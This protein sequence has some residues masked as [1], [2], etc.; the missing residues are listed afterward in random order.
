M[1]F[2]GLDCHCGSLPE[3]ERMIKSGFLV[4]ISL[5]ILSCGIPGPF[6]ITPSQYLI[7]RGDTLFAIA[8]RYDL[9]MKT[10]ASWNGIHPPF[11]IHPGQRLNLRPPP[12]YNKSATQKPTSAPQQTAERP[13]ILESKP[14]KLPP[15]TKPSAK[16][17]ASAPEKLPPTTKPPGKAP[18][19]AEKYPSNKEVTWGWPT[20][21]KVVAEFSANGVGKTGINIQ[22]KTGQSVVAAASGKVVYSGNGL[23]GYGELIIIKHSDE[24]LSAYAYNRKRLVKEGSWA[25]KGQRIAELGGAGKDLS[26]LHFEIRKKGKP[27]N[28][29]KYLPPH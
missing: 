7:R 2:R 21:G 15:T 18:A 3:F 10:L 29:L 16:V 26:V 23:K 11:V 20:V 27:V 9:E 6:N 1:E 14:E 17:S 4:L 5:A 28:P 19:P 22:G 24:L 25:K 12:G 13:T 8:W